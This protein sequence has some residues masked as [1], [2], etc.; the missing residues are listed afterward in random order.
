[1]P[2]YFLR[3][4][5][6]SSLGESTQLAR[7]LV[8]QMGA[9][10]LLTV[11]FSQEVFLLAHSSP[12]APCRSCPTACNSDATAADSIP[13]AVAL[14]AADSPSLLVAL[15]S[16]PSLILTL[17]DSCLSS[18]VVHF[19]PHSQHLTRL[20]LLPLRAGVLRS[21][22][23]CPLQVTLRLRLAVLVVVT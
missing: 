22:V 8:L 7:G 13:S 19:L 11:L 21:E 14:H 18:A 15:L 10:L 6:M 4:P 3:L 5:V 9:S 23:C 20:S 16:L 2:F 17:P 1:M 12:P